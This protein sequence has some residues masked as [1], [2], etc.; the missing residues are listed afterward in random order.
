MDIVHGG[1]TATLIDS[2]F[3]YLGTLVNDLSPVATANL[4]LNYK[5]PIKVEKE[6]LLNCEVK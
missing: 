1:F 4:N 6:Y 5:K 2:I 3:G